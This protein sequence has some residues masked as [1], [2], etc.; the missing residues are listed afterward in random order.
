MRVVVQHTAVA[1]GRAA[2]LSMMAALPLPLPKQVQARLATQMR[3]PTLQAQT[4]TP[5]LKVPMQPLM[6]MAMRMAVRAQIAALLKL[7]LKLRQAV[8]TMAPAH[9]PL[10]M[11]MLML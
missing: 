6:W 7:K 11:R 5:D 10:V 8:L 4:W 1:G 3:T 9:L 2:R